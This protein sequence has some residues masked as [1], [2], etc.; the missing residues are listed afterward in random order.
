MDNSIPDLLIKSFFQEL[1]KIL[2]RSDNGITEVWCKPSEINC[3]KEFN[4]NELNNFLLS[5][6]FI[7]NERW[8]HIA[9]DKIQFIIEALRFLELDVKKLSELLDYSGFE[10]LIQKILEMNNFRAIKNF[11][12]TDKSNYKI[13]TSQKRYEIDVIGI[14]RNYVIVADAKQW[15]RKDSFSSINKAANLQYRR[16]I[17]LKK[18]PEAFAKIIEDLFGINKKIREYLPFTLIPIMVTLEDNYI[19]INENQVPLVCISKF[20]A[21]LY[22]FQNYLDYYNTIKINKV[23]I[24]KQ[25]F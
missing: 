25:L 11:R 3:L 18:N 13:K 22:E 19:R 21:F 6:D 17:A 12:F 16:I 2:E 5:F 14:Y 20:N 1:L 15:R 8:N 23:T 9:I 7:Q 4:K 24:Q 10:A